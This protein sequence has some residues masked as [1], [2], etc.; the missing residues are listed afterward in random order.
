MVCYGSPVPTLILTACMYA[1]Y[2]VESL[3]KTTLVTSRP[4]RRQLRGSRRCSTAMLASRVV[5]EAVKAS[6]QF[7]RFSTASAMRM[8]KRG[9]L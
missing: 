1:V 4:H 9:A 5:A 6:G 2:R 7:F 8:V 3:L